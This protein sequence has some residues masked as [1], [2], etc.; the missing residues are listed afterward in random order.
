MKYLVVDYIVNNLTKKMLLNL[1]KNNHYNKR[2][3]RINDLTLFDGVLVVPLMRRMVEEGFNIFST[4]VKTF[5]LKFCCFFL[6]FAI[7]SSFCILFILE[8]CLKDKHSKRNWT[9]LYIIFKFKIIS[10]QRGFL[11]FRIQNFLFQQN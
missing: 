9:S 1:N 11:N 3:T 10:Q 6:I 8:I 7:L 5:I 2:R 4:F